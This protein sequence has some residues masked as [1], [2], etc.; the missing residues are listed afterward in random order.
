MDELMFFTLFLCGDLLRRKKEGKRLT[1]REKWLFLQLI[2]L[3]ANRVAIQQ[4]YAI[5][6]ENKA[7]M[8]EARAEKF[9][10]EV[11]PV[12]D[13]DIQDMDETVRQVLL[14]AAA[15]KEFKLDQHLI[16]R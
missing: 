15:C 16:S 13:E 2:C 6:L 3:I 8:L 9:A 7:R 4:Q 14:L 11:L 5:E 1:F 10:E 12:F